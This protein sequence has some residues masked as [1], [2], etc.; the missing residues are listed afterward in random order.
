MNHYTEST[1][2]GHWPTA[3]DA[4]CAIAQHL[5]HISHVGID[6]LLAETAPGGAR[7]ITVGYAADAPADDAT[8]VE[9]F[10][11]QAWN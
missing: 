7:R 11:K 6:Y 9:A 3:E 1:L 4:R 10:L 2:T 5:A 8:I